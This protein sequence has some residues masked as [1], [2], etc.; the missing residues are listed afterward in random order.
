MFRNA[1]QA[2]EQGSKATA[3]GRQLEARALFKAARILEDCQ[4]GWESPDHQQ[5]LSE[6]LRLNLKLWTVFQTELARPDHELPLDLRTDLLRLSAFIDRRSFQ[7]MSRPDPGKLQAL[8]DINR[9]IA[10]GLASAP[11]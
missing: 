7:M 9:N 10:M 8:I 5:R 11:S 4:R 3:S 6:A 1:Q 2:Y